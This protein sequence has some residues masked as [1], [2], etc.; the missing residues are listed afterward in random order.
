MPAAQAKAKQAAMK[1]AKKKKLGLAEPDMKALTAP[2]TGI[3]TIV[4]ACSNQVS[5]TNQGAIMAR[6]KAKPD[7]AEL[8]AALAASSAIQPE[9]RPTAAEEKEAIKARKAAERE[10]ARQQK[11]AEKEA[12]RQQK[13]AE[14]AAAKADREADGTQPVMAALRA[15]TAAGVYV[16]GLNGQ[17]RSTDAVAVALEAIPAQKTVE[18]LLKILGDTENKYAALNYGQQSMNLRNRLRGAVR[19]G[20]VTLEFVQ[21]VAAEYAAEAVA[22]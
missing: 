13:A 4:E 21:A 19:K 5:P 14:R 12:A 20:T 18:A 11:A 7:P 9:Q 2:R 3:D 17:L 6:T 1:A 15:R 10:A 16:K 8:E 22:A